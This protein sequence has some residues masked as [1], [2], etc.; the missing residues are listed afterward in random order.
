[1]KWRSTVDMIKKCKE[2][3]IPSNYTTF[4]DLI[5]ASDL[6]SGLLKVLTNTGCLPK[7]KSIIESLH[8][9]MCG[10]VQ[11]D[12]NAS[13]P[14]KTL[15]SFKQGCVLAPR[16]FEIIFSLLLKHAFGTAYQGIYLPTLTDGKQFKLS[17]LETTT[18]VK[19]KSL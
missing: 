12:G 6:V 5:K 4:I 18:K 11:Y 16:L 10:T 19:K 2:Q 13:E 3:N 1:M 8:N 7:I 17:R 14:F 9:K 15:S